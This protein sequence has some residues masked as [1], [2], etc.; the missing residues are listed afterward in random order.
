VKPRVFL[1]S[2]VMSETQFD[3]AGLLV[4]AVQC[5]DLRVKDQILHILNAICVLNHALEICPE[6]LECV[7]SP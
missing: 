2:F 5:S 1:C 7:Q 6:F 3:L 4:S